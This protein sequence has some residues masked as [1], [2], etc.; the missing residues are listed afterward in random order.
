MESHETDKLERKKKLN[1]ND[2]TEKERDTNYLITEGLE[3][4]PERNLKDRK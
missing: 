4:V 3:N 1:G 2:R